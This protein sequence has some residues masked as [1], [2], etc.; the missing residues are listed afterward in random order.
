MMVTIT[1]MV[2]MVLISILTF[3]LMV[4]IDLMVTSISIVIMLMALARTTLMKRQ[5]MTGKMTNCKI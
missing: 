4:I 5:T 3:Y 1:S 2:V